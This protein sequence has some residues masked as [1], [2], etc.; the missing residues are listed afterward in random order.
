MTT[1]EA[2][3]RAVYAELFPDRDQ[4]QMTLSDTELAMLVYT[5]RRIERANKTRVIEPAYAHDHEPQ[6]TVRSRNHVELEA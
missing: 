5:H 2:E 1:I 6:P 4:S 3:L